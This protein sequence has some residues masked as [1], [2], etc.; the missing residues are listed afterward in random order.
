MIRAL[1][2]WSMQLRLLM[3]AAAAALI[4]FGITELR[5]MPLDVV[6]EFSRPYVEIQTEALG[7]SAAEVE[8][9]I[10]VPL[11]ADMLNG[12]SWVDEIRSDSIPGL[13]SIVLF[14]ESGTDLLV[15]RQMVQE[16]LV[17]VHALPNV[18]RPP[19]MLQPLSSASRFMAVGLTSNSRSLIETSVLARWTIVPRLLGVPGVAN[20]SI[21]GQRR[22]QL[23]VQVDPER[24]RDQGVTLHQIIASAGNALWVSPLSFLDASTPGTGGWIETPNQ[25]LGV[26][27]LL[28]VSTPEDLAK[29]TVEGTIMRLGDLAR[30]VENHQPLIGDAVVEDA[31]AL[32]LVIDK[33]PWARTVDVTRNVEAALAALQ[34]GLP[35]IEMDSS[36]FRPATYLELAVGNL[37]KGLLMAAVLVVVAVF[38]LLFN[39]RTALIGTLAVLVSALAAGAVLYVRGVTINMMI[40]AGLMMALAALIDDALID[41][42]NIAR[43]LRENRKGE[44][45]KSA[46]R[47]ILEAALQ[48]RSPIVYATLIVLLAVAPVYFME[49]V[50]GAF[51]QP[52]AL[53]YA[54]ALLASM[55]VAV[56][57]TPALSLLLLSGGAG[58]DRE[59]PLLEALQRG[60][61]AILSRGSTRA[62]GP[63]FLVGVAAVGVAV[64]VGLVVFPPLGQPVLPTFRE[65]D[66]LVE[67]DGA[68]GTS[69]LEMRR[70]LGRASRELRSIP[71]VRS[72]SAHLGR[73]VMSDR[74]TDVGSG[75]LSVSIDPTADYDAAVAAIRKTAAG[76]PGFDIDV[77]TYLNERIREEAGD[78]DEALVVRIYGDDLERLGSKAEE[79]KQLLSRIDGVVGPYVEYPEEHPNLEIETNLAKASQHGLKPGDVRRAATTLLSGITVGSLFEEQKVFDV[80]VWGTP[81]IRQNL[82]DVGNLLIDTPR[83]GHVRLKDV[84]DLR[85]ASAPK[86]ISREA[87]ARHIDVTADIQGR[88]FAA[89]SAEVE[90]RIRSE[91]EFPL[92]FRAEILGDYAA[93]VAAQQR[94]RAFSVGA[95]VGILLLLQ[96]AF[97]SWG[98]AF[99]FFLSLPIAVLG[100]VVASLASG[101]PVSLGSILGLLAVFGIAVRHGLTLIG[102]CHHLAKLGGGSLSPELVRRGTRE[103][104]VPIVMTSVAVALAFLP[105]ALLG[106]IAGHEILHPMAVVVLGGLV[107]ATLVTLLVVPALCLRFGTGA[108]PLDIIGEEDL[109]GPIASLSTNPTRQQVG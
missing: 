103:R 73:A 52:I 77:N 69:E 72:V 91:V 9:M 16:R 20:V 2:A 96:A 47:V 83:G 95:A 56:T 33:F 23:Q 66:I 106:N 70:I 5:R 1:V 81:E 29:V 44:G 46:A 38:G 85:I 61:D 48:M 18:S 90:E 92:E 104:S 108:E 24:L 97:G 14:F 6:P 35:G 55:S 101:S 3:V 93:R 40:I 98:L 54:L 27:H 78:P 74:V 4:F 88:D 75:E 10:T 26:Q 8:A 99:F 100:G 59:S 45:E 84:S 82:S 64:L 7:L 30:V 11:E 31:P 37:S 39:W 105:F 28:P 13:S 34:P 42:Q 15:A 32:M 63:V 25:R 102:H 43:R 89:V 79:V 68:P 19:A 80:V 71:G 49:G 87:V 58:G 109:Q 86:V 94:V 22:K 53:S 12:V 36:L 41:A 65:R 21:W 76:Y 17:G 51:S 50:S 60:V 107:S 62:P 67:L 57:L